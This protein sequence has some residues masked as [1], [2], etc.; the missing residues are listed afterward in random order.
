MPHFFMIDINAE[1]PHE[2]FP[3]RTPESIFSHEVH[4]FDDCLLIA[5]QMYGVV[6]VE[7]SE[8]EFFP[9]VICLI[10]CEF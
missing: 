1:S 5:T 4:E 8:G 2:F 6:D 9:K 10:H 3:L 7:P